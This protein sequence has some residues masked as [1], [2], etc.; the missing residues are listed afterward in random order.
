MLNRIIYIC[1]SCSFISECLTYIIYGELPLTK[2]EYFKLNLI[3]KFSSINHLKSYL[4]KLK[5][6]Y[7][8]FYPSTK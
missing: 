2:L 8:D 4:T 6:K 5:I 3:I 7:V 1:N